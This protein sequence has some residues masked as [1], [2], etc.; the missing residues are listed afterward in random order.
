MKT[1]IRRREKNN[2]L[3]VVYGGWGSDENIYVPICD[4]DYD[5]ILF[6]NYSA[7]EPLILPDMKTYR[8]VILIGFSLGVFAA[9]YLSPKSGIIPDVSIAVNGTPFPVDEKYG[10]RRK[11]FEGTLNNITE[12]TIG[13]FYLRMFG[14]KKTFNAVKDILPRRTL[15]SLHDEL[16]WLYNRIMEG[17][18]TGFRWDYAVTSENDRVF[19]SE[20]QKSYWSS[21]TGI[22]QIMLPLPHYFFHKWGKISSFLSFVESWK[23]LSD[24][25]RKEVLKK[26]KCL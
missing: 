8:K 1:Y 24:K 6:Y 19:P 5:F 14:D 11:V 15:K 22:E 7:D 10:I 26:I 18:G 12:A 17:D 9:S 23:S 21:V 2:Q 20:S 16:R 13:K 4:D 3:L 25:E